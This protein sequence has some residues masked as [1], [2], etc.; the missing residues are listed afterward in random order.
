MG[1]VMISVDLDEA[2]EGMSRRDKLNMLEWLYDDGFFDNHPKKEIRRHGYCD[3]DSFDEIEFK[4]AI[5]KIQDAY[6]RLTPE[7][8][9]DIKKIAKTL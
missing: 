2:Y 4:S 5:M 7:Q 6:Y 3:E 8:E 9:E 1:Y